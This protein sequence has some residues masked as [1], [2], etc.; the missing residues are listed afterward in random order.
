VGVTSRD[1]CE[2]LYWD[3][4]GLDDSDKVGFNCWEKVRPNIGTRHEIET[5]SATLVCA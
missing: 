1:N 3:K 2:T 4:V 5:H